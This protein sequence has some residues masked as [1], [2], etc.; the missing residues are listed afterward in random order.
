MLGHCIRASLLVLMTALTSCASHGP[1]AVDPDRD[2]GGLRDLVNG[3]SEDGGVD[4]FLV[5]GMRVDAPDNYADVINAVRRRLDLVSADSTVALPIGLVTTKPVIWI[6]GVNVFKDLDWKDFRPQVTIERYFTR[7]G[8][9]RVNFYRFEYWEAL[10]YIKCRFIL[11]P[12]VRVVGTSPR[13]DY[14]N[15]SYSLSTGRPWSSSGKYVNRALKT[16]IMEWGL[17]DAMIATSGYRAVLHQAVREMLAMAVREAR[18]HAGLPDS[19]TGRSAEEELQ[20]IAERNKTRFAFI[21]ESLGSYVVHDAMAVEVFH[22]IQAAQERAFFEPD[23]ATRDFEGRAPVLVVCGASQV[24]MFA[25]QLALLRVSE[26]QVEDAHGHVVGAEP[27]ETTPS[28]T[29][30]AKEQRSHFFRGCP[31]KSSSPSSGQPAAAGFGAQQ[32]V[33]FHEPSDI[34]TYYTSDQPGQVGT[35]NHNTTNVVIP[36]AT[37]WIWGVLANPIQAHT[38][39]PDQ[40]RLMDLVVCG[41][42]GG[43]TLPCPH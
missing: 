4:I 32:V 11:T 43:R 22:P 2:F 25:N 33:A 40:D 38:G 23:A 34:L 16:E 14:C 21:S 17:A 12:D 39:Q 41:R 10:A 35:D 24:H 31:A 19:P 18:S 42:G 20:T 36:Y 1:A 15:R 13:S 30:I 26:L 37:Q 27:T 28:E 8:H 5:H 6:D 3:V 29:D 9:I 7:A